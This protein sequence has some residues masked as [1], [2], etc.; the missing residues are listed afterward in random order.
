LN[1]YTY[2]I[3]HERYYRSSKYLDNT[4]TYLKGQSMPT[5]IYVTFLQADIHHH[6]L[7][8][9]INIVEKHFP[10]PPSTV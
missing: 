5:Q 1:E 9:I 10:P 2:V 7:S 6:L 4:N 8:N 3:E